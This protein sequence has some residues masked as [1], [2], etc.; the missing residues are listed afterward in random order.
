MSKVLFEDVVPLIPQEGGPGGAVFW[1]PGLVGS[2]VVPLMEWGLCS[3]AVRLDMRAQGSC[4][5]ASHSNLSPCL[6]STQGINYHA[7]HISIWDLQE[8]AT[9]VEPSF[10]MQ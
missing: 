9:N 10:G 3:G 2:P 1:L 4:S 8:Q 7:C 5:A 6:Q